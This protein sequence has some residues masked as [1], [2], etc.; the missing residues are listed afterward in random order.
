MLLE[1][2]LRVSL[3]YVGRIDHFLELPDL[4]LREPAEPVF[5]MRQDGSARNKEPPLALHEITQDARDANGEV[6][7]GL[8]R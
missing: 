5:E 6:P 4:V 7:V 1:E 3:C 2:P 8:N